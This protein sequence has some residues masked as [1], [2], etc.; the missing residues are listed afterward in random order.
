MAQYTHP[1]PIQEGFRDCKGA[2]G[3]SPA[4]DSRIGIGLDDWRLWHPV[5]VQ[6]GQGV[7]AP[8]W[9]RIRR[10]VLLRVLR[11]SAAEE[12]AL[13]HC[14]LAAGNEPSLSRPMGEQEVQLAT[15][16]GMIRGTFKSP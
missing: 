4:L 8:L 9:L 5:W 10:Y 11:G 15:V 6:S 13:P 16:P 12:T 2:W 3:V 1:L 14:I 7:R